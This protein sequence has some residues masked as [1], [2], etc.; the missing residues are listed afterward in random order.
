[1]QT[2]GAGRESFVGSCRSSSQLFEIRLRLR[3]K[4]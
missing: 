2:H 3:E 4:L 1:M